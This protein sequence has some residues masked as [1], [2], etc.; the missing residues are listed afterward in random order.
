MMPTSLHQIN[1]TNGLMFV[2]LFLLT[3]Q[4]FSNDLTLEDV[5]EAVNFSRKVIED[6]ELQVLYFEAPKHDLS[7]EDDL[8]S[9]ETD[10]AQL[11]EK[12]SMSK[13]QKEKDE[14]Q[15]ELESAES[16][17]ENITKSRGSYEQQN[18]VF[19]AKRNSPNYTDLL[20]NLY[21]RIHVI[22]RHDEY[23]GDLG[24]FDSY[25]RALN[26]PVQYHNTV[27]LD[28]ENTIYLWADGT[29]TN[30][31]SLEP[32][33]LAMVDIPFNLWGRSVFEINPEDVIEFNKKELHNNS[34]VYTIE[35][36]LDSN[37]SL[38][39]SS[40]GLP[41]DKATHKVWVDPESGFSVIR[42]EIRLYVERKTTI[43]QVFRYGQ[44][45]EFRGGIWYPGTVENTTNNPL[46]PT[47]IAVS[48]SYEIK[49][50]DFNIGIPSGF[51]TN[52]VDDGRRLGLMN[53]PQN[54]SSN[55]QNNQ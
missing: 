35:F 50:A 29:R 40:T 5:V 43:V 46:D 31:G 19:Q 16:R 13:R 25:T 52:L 10:I 45:R 1:L 27:V 21:Y 20:K 9:I 2:L 15:K 24:G 53:Y 17:L 37:L 44:F 8:D 36:E 30:S 32:P 41:V 11:I 3:Y 28:G 48:Y 47:K 12:Y 14:I 38:F 49:E 6:G 23:E 54:K 34:A 18:I 7:S 42:L 4:S 55:L 39:R 51:F 26:L 33:H 22:D